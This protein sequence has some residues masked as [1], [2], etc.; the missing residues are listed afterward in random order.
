M[1]FQP[2]VNA[3]TFLLY[4]LGV[5]ALCTGFNLATEATRRLGEKTEPP[6]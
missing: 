4:C 2:L 1:D 6:R 5:M 3:A